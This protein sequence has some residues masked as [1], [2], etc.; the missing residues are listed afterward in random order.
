MKKTIEQIIDKFRPFVASH[1]GDVKLTEYKDNTAKIS[2]GG[3][4]AHCPLVELSY[5]RILRGLIE[6][7]V[8]GVRIVF[9]NIPSNKTKN[10]KSRIREDQ[11]RVEY[12]KNRR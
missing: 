6:E 11:R 4:C 3:A 5:N 1:G 12:I 10:A 2:V 9:S 8:P 7:K